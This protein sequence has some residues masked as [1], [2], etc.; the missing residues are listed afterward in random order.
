MGFSK[1]LMLILLALAFIAALWMFG[2]TVFKGVTKWLLWA[3]AALCVCAGVIALL[4]AEGR[5][6][7]YLGGLALWAFAAYAVRVAGA[8]RKRS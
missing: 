3:L 8:S 1:Y 7:A 2:R 5:P 6:L 4:E